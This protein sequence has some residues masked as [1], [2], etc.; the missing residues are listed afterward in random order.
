LINVS[1]IQAPKFQVLMRGKRRQTALAVP[2]FNIMTYNLLFI[3]QEHLHGTAPAMHGNAQ[4][5]TV[6]HG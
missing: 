1:Q 2:V 4:L 5:C 6:L 3:R